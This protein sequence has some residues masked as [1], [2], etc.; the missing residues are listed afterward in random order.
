MFTPHIAE[1][2]V[3]SGFGQ[4]GAKKTAH[5]ACAHNSNFH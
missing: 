5:G 4:H 3:I 2:D 1:P